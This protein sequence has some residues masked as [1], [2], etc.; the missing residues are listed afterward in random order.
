VY[1][2]CPAPPTDPPNPNNP[3]QSAGYG[4]AIRQEIGLLYN[5]M[6]AAGPGYELP[7]AIIDRIFYGNAAQ[8]MKDTKLPAPGAG[9]GLDFDE[10]R[11]FLRDLFFAEWRDNVNIVG[12]DAAPELGDFMPAEL[13]NKAP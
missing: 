1:E 11:Q 4:D 8:L 9:T 6:T 12:E 10:A 2:P 5:A 13:M 7:R 3:T